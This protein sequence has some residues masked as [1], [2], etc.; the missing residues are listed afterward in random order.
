M[1]G[2]QRGRFVR[3]YVEMVVAM[4]VSMGVLAA[5][6]AG[7]E[8][9]TALRSP[10]SPAFAAVKMAFDMS[11]GMVVWMRYRGHGWA[12]TLEMVGAMFAPAVVLAAL[13]ATGVISGAVLMIV[14]HVGML[15]LMLL[16]MLRRRAEYGAAHTATGVCDDALAPVA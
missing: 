12:A 16:V 13:S 3:H 8:A 4:F 14:M 2:T 6:T 7:V 10:G 9:L 11:V 15:P 1:R 5:A